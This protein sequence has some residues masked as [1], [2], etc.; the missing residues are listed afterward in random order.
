[1]E[2][3]GL[4][5][6][7]CIKAMV[8]GRVPSSMVGKIVGGTYCEQLE[9]IW[10]DY[11]TGIWATMP[12]RARKIWT[13]MVRGGRID[14][15]RLRN[16]APPDTSCGIWLVNGLNMETE[17]LQSVLSL[18]E[19]LSKAPAERR[20]KLFS[21][22]SSDVQC[23]FREI[24]DGLFGEMFP[25]FAGLPRNVPSGIFLESLKKRLQEIFG[26]LPSF[27]GTPMF[28]QLLKVLAPA[29]K[30]AIRGSNSGKI[31]AIQIPDHLSQ[32]VRPKS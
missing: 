27:E 24:P 14:Q 25:D 2:I 30:D 16:Q 29:L 18:F 4:S 19:F 28:P 6:S 9:S 1:M 11:S 3:V 17:D 10:E 32:A 12:L 22:L 23:L 20:E 5:I 7:R 31:Q 8:E 21:G 15:P 26:D 13:E